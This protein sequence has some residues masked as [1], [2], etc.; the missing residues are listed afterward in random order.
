MSV[1][2]LSIFVVGI[3]YAN[4]DG[5]DRRAELDR[6]APGDPV[7]LRREPG[8]PHDPDAV[9]VF[10]D[11]GVQVGYLPADF[12]REIGQRMLAEPYAAV[13]HWLGEQV[14]AIRVQFGGGSPTLPQGHQPREPGDFLPD[15]DG[16][17]WGA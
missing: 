10:S 1:S 3:N 6:L 15:A 5:S 11:R 2:E 12:C 8:N 17:I 14:A 13:F 16:P 9:A 7:E 4:D